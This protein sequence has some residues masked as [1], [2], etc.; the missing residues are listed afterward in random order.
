MPYPALSIVMKKTF[1]LSLFFFAI[2]LRLNAQHSTTFYKQFSVNPYLFNPAY[3]ASN[4][5]M[6]ASVGY[7]QQWSNFKDAPRS[8]GFSLQFPSSDRVS[9]GF[10]YSSDRQ[11]LLRSSSLMVTFGY[12]V[13]INVD[14]SLRFGISGGVGMNKIDLNADEMNNIDPAIMNLTSNTFFVNGNAGIL[15]VLGRLRIG[16]T[17]TDLFKSNAFNSLSLNEFKFSNLKN[18]LYSLSYKWTLPNSE[19][20]AI[21]P[22]FLYRQTEDG[23]Q[24]SW[25]AAAMAYFKNDFWTGGSFNQ[26]NGLALFMGVNLKSKFSLSYS[27]E[28]P[29]FESAISA[30][31]H[32]VH[33]GIKFGSTNKRTKLIT[34]AR[35]RPRLPMANET[36][37]VK[38]DSKGSNERPGSRRSARMV[39]PETN[40]EEIFEIIEIDPT[41][42]N[43][44]AN[45]VSP[46]VAYPKKSESFTLTTG[47]TYVVVG[48]F[49]GLSHSI[50]FAREL[51]VKGYI[52][53]VA[54]NPKNNL[55]YTYLIST[56]D[57]N[58]AR[59]VRN[60]FRWK[61][62]LKEVW[63]YTQAE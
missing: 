53:N 51:M 37:S 8:A 4:N 30:S 27:Y 31:S 48:V 40:Y 42:D 56:R 5:A 52:V 47:R 35:S 36:P 44:T 50:N 63:I 15:Y 57:L 46:G 24:N 12:L 7:R 14:Q 17:F 55:Y 60:Q 33:L 19:N 39:S 20:I 58:E 41:T 61:N 54:L 6:E 26:N 38:S 11:I 16:F 59:K 62:P 22:Y 34:K 21:E 10:S 23:V 43:G 29:P 13:P 18:R 49:K 2:L 1:T 28:F 3:V 9:L 32:E 45:S 25:E